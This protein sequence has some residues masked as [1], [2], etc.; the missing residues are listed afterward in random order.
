MI[1][2]VDPLF[3]EEFRDLVEKRIENFWGYGSLEAPVWFVGMEEGLEG[4]FGENHI[5]DRFRATD[6][7]QV[8]DLREGMEKVDDHI[9]WFKLGGPIQPTWKYPLALYLYLKNNRVPTTDEIREYQNLILGDSKMKKAAAIEL[10]PLPSNKAHE[11]TWIYG[12]LGIDGLQTRTEYLAAHKPRR[13]RELQSLLQQ[14]S[15][16]LVIF[17][18]LTYMIDW[19]SVIGNVPVEITKGMYFAKSDATAYCVI[20][21]GAS[22]GMSYKRICEFAEKVRGTIISDQAS[23][24]SLKHP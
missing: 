8:T 17:Y 11:S 18:S 12:N 15:P 14:Y 9:R 6:N 16:E 5:L 24:A 13:V 1:Q 2:K 10:M 19:T 4:G 7:K 22:F 3:R 21:Q 23:F 20:P